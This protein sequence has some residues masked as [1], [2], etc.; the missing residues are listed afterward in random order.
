LNERRVWIAASGVAVVALARALSAVPPEDFAHDANEEQRHEA[1]GWVVAEEPA[2]R[3]AAAK[4]FPSDP[5]SQD[6]DFHFRELKRARSYAAEHD[7]RLSNVLGAFDD[8]MREHWETQVSVLPATKV[9][10]C[11]PRPIY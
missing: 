10:P 8:G 9:P 7:L 4:E 3:R 6:D 1:Y 2:M 11:R 5:W